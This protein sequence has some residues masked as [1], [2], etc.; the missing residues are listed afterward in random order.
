MIAI[1][2]RDDYDFDDVSDYYSS[3]CCRGGMRPFFPP[4]QISQRQTYIN[5]FTQCADQIVYQT[6]VTMY[7]YIIY[8]YNIIYNNIY[9]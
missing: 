5:T 6:C 3:Y 9:I 8:I 2:F 1:F 7:L 4:M